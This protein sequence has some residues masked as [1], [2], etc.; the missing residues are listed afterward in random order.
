MRWAEASDHIV[1]PTGG[2]IILL[3]HECDAAQAF[4]QCRDEILVGQI[5][6]QPDTLFA[7]AVEKK[8][9]RRPYGVETVEP[10]RMFVDMSVDRN[11]I[12]MNELCGF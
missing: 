2:I 3:M 6:F 11:E 8:D 4:F 1:V 5:S 10:H 7:V 12:L 9:R